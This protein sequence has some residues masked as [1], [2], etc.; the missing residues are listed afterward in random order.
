MVKTKWGDLEKH[1]IHVTFA[2][3][4][5]SVNTLKTFFK[6]ICNTN[7]L[8]TKIISPNIIINI[9]FMIQITEYSSKSK[10]WKKKNI[11]KSV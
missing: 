11:Q 3:V 10:N 4:A 9:I 2:M 7:C 8:N 1:G 5:T 6:S